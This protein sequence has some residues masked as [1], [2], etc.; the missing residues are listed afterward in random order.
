VLVAVVSDTHL[1]RG[2]RRLPDACV[3][4]MRAADL[5]L[6]GG[7][8]ATVAALEELRALGPPVHAVAGNVDEPALQA[9][10]PPELVVEVGQVKIAM[11]H[12]PGPARGREQRLRARFPSADAIVYGHTH[13]PQVD[14]LGGVWILNPGSPT[15]RRRAPARTMIVLEIRRRKIRP[16][17]LVVG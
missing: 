11:T 4:R 8:V 9:E 13:M 16:E 6:H 12:I 7:D 17:L 15:E 10:L 14:E 3:E 5:I 2:S 1:P